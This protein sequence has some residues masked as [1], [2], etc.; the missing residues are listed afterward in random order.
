ML[1]SLN[2]Q[3][4]G[5][6][7]VYVLFIV[8]IIFTLIARRW[9]LTLVTVVGALFIYAAVIG[10]AEVLWYYLKNWFDIDISYR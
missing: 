5:A 10:I 8:T 4:L 6:Q 2:L 7:G 1:E 9:K 3:L